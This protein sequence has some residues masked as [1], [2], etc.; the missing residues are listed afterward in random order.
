MLKTHERIITAQDLAQE[1]HT[2]LTNAR[3]EPLVIT[4]AGRPAAYLLSVEL[5]DD[6]MRQLATW[7]ET[8]LA[9]AIAVAEEQFTKGAYK[10]LE[11][12]RVI[13]EAAWK[14]QESSE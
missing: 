11:E 10:T 5:F 14:E 3:Q 8:E 2:A 6:L 9:T 4:D 12:A 13:A 7:E 1:V